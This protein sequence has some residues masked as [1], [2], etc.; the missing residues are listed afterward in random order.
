M[1]FSENRNAKHRFSTRRRRIL[2]IRARLIKDNGATTYR[3]GQN[4]PY[5]LTML[6]AAM[7]PCVRAGRLLR[8]A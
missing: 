7:M 5:L 6:L 8:I 2:V 1:T 4:G 3:H